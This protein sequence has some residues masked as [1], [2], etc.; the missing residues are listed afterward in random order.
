MS[1]YDV[2]SQ[3]SCITVSKTHVSYEHIERPSWLIS[4]FEVVM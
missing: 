1:L 2:G 3:A 4:D